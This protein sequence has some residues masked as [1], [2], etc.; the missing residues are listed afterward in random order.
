MAIKVF[1]TYKS[2]LSLCDCYISVYVL[3]GCSTVVVIV[4]M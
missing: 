3:F 2:Y 4:M 1:I